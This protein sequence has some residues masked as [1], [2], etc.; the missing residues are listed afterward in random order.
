M[1]ASARR[2]Q[3]QK[4]YLRAVAAVRW[5]TERNRILRGQRP[6]AGHMA[7]LRALDASLH[8]VSEDATPLKTLML[9]DV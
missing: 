5:A 6:N 1:D 7:A 8:R 9:T 4:I 2:F 3:A